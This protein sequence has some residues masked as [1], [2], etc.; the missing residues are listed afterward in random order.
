M[1]Q[2]EVSKVTQ[3]I[4]LGPDSDEIAVTKLSMFVL[5]V[6]GDGGDPPPRQAFTYAQKIRRG[7]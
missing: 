2:V 4:A 7:R 6:P 3:F 5:L 1:S